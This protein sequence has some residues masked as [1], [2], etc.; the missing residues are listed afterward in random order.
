MGHNL[1]A[2]DLLHLQAASPDLR[3]LQLPAVDTLRLNPL[4]FPRNPYHHLV[5]HYQDGGLKRGRVNYP[6]LD[7]QALGD[8]AGVAMAPAMFTSRNERPDAPAAYLLPFQEIP[9][10]FI[11]EPPKHDFNWRLV[12]QIAGGDMTGARQ[13]HAPVL[14]HR[15][16]QFVSTCFFYTNPDE[17]P[18]PPPLVTLAIYD[19]YRLIEYPHIPEG[20]GTKTCRIAFG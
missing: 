1:I 9:L 19:R 13:P 16:R 7:V 11:A 20:Y 15:K 3:L 5:K 4:A 2:F 6:E 14:V 17:R 18:V 8:Y 12:R 10:M